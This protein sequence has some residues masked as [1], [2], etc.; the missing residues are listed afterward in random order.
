MSGAAIGTGVAVGVAGAAASYGLSQLNKPSAYNPSANNALGFQ[1]Q[2]AIQNLTKGY[3][4]SVSGYG[5]VFQGQEAGLSKTYGK[6]GAAASGNYLTNTGNALSQ[7]GTGIQNLA[8][9]AP[10]NEL[11]AAQSGLNFNYNNLGNYGAIANSLS[12]SAQQSQLGLINNS[13]PSWQQQYAQGMEN[14]GQMQQGLIASDVQGNLGRTAGLNAIQSGVGG[15]SGLGRNL[16]ARDLGLTSQQLQQQ[17]TAQAQALGQQQYG[18]TVAGMLTNP[19]AIYQTGGVNSGQAMNAAAL[20]TNIAA[21]GLQTGLQGNLSTQGVNYGQ[22]MNLYGNQFNTGVQADTAIMQAQDYAAAQAM[23]A[24]AGAITGNYQN[25]MNGNIAQFQSQ[26]QLSAYNNQANQQLLSGVMSGIGSGIA[27]GIGA[28]NN[29][30][31][32]GYGLEGAGYSN[33][34]GADQMSGTGFYESPQAAMNANGWSSNSIGFTPGQ[35][36]YHY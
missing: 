10:Q 6:Q 25:Q 8:N 18:M 29:G 2:M 9:F 13:M 24:N 36:Y 3:T 7:Y 32:A 28:Y 35:G 34:F 1:N 14:A 16:M 12:N 20:G 26:N 15:G 33:N 27:G 21:T 11:N 30:G 19:N 5:N 4:G 23:Q 31:L 22:L 17:G